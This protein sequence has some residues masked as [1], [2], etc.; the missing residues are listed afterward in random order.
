MTRENAT[1]ATKNEEVNKIHEL[2]EKLKLVE[3]EAQQLRFDNTRL[4]SSLVIA[5]QLLTD[6]TQ[7]CPI[8]GKKMLLID[9]NT[10]AYI[11]A[12][13]NT[14]CSAYKNP[15]R[16]LKKEDLIWLDLASAQASK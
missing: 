4:Q 15:I 10:S 5:K 8:C 13:N 7:S 3:A 6:L 11:L 9:W 12:C 2:Q 16:T 1:V 14:T